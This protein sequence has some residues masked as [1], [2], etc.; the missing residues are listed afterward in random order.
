[1]WKEYIGH[2]LLIKQH[3]YSKNLKIK[4]LKIGLVIVDIKRSHG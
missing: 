1:M 2:L 3:S 4:I